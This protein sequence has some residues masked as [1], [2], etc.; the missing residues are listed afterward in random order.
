MK[1]LADKA[2]EL[3]LKYNLKDEAKLIADE[4]DRVMYI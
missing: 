2:Y 1:Q 3:S 4:G